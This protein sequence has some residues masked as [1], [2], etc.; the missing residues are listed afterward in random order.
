MKL[1]ALGLLF[2]SSL[3]L[4]F[5][6]ELLI[7]EQ[8]N[9]DKKG[10]LIEDKIDLIVT[11]DDCPKYY[12][13]KTFRTRLQDS[14]YFRE[15][16]KNN[17][18][19]EL[20]LHVKSIK[21]FSKLMYLLHGRPT[22][23]YNKTE[24][25]EAMMLQEKF[26]FN[27]LNGLLLGFIKKESDLNSLHAGELTHILIAMHDSIFPFG[28]ECTKQILNYIRNYFYL[29]KNCSISEIVTYLSE[30]P[31]LRELIYE[32]IKQVYEQMDLG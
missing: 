29:N 32:I 12:I 18:C 8:Y 1:I 24:L 27:S 7:D 11:S 17:N 9:A 13:F 28:K 10:A 4:T 16:L 21:A 5:A 31:H 14:L 3:E 30:Y 6:M 22:N 25:F 23:F 20:T 26:Q 15:E 2:F 19:P